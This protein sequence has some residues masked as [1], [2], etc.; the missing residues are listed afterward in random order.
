VRFCGAKVIQ[1]SEIQ[2]LNTLFPT[3]TTGTAGA[4]AFLGAAKQA[5]GAVDYC[6]DAEGD[7]EDDNDVLNVHNRP[8]L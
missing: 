2:V 3:I 7:Y 8:D 1:L 6:D 5:N 4:T